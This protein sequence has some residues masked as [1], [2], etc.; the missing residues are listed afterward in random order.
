MLRPLISVVAVMSVGFATAAQAASIK[1]VDGHVFVSKGV[2]YAPGKAGLQ[3]I[4]GDKA[5]VSNNSKAVVLFEDG[6][7]Y[8]LLPG[9]VLSIQK[10]S[11][12]LDAS[13][14]SDRAPDLPGRMSQSGPE[15][16]GLFGLST[17]VVVAG[18]VVA[19]AVTAAVVAATE[20]EESKSP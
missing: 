15:A 9:K 14:V 19:A 3:L 18:V 17:P 1:S 2:G 12:C 7:S 20:E 16:G 6:C 10:L 13:R 5:V 11:P 8:T 4:P